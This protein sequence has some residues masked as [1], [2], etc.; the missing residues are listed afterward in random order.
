ME[1]VLLK[2]KVKY[3]IIIDIKGIWRNRI[4]VSTK[5]QVIAG[6][7]FDNCLMNAARCSLHDHRGVRRS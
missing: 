1:M 4:M 2:S 5:K 6:F 7:K 3:G